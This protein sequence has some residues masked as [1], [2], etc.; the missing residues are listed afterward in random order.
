MYSLFLGFGL[1]IGAELYQTMLSKPLLGGTDYMCTSS[2]DPEGGWWQRTPSL[3]W[4][5]LTVPCYS[6]FLSLR[7]GAVVGRRELVSFVLV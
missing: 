7:F 4:A 5:F 2:H 1:A 3:W 6:L